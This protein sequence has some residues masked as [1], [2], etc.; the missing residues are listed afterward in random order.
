MSTKDTT[1]TPGELA[2]ERLEQAASRAQEREHRLHRLLG[3]RGHLEGCPHELTLAASGVIEGYELLAAAP[4]SELRGQGVAAGD[5]ITAVRCG[6]CGGIKYY[7][8][9]LDALLER[10]TP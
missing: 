2:R 1:A 5:T 8:G 4:G 3:V 7:A 10:V 9:R 6:T